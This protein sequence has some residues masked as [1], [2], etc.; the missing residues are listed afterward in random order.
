MVIQQT[1]DPGASP[2]EFMHTKQISCTTQSEI[3]SI[4]SNRLRIAAALAAC[5]FMASAGEAGAS[6]SDKWQYTLLNPTPK[7]SMREMST[8]RPDQT[9]SAMTV[10][11]GHFQIE[12]D[13]VNATF[14]RDTSGGQ[15]ITTESWSIAPVNLK[16]GL[17]NNVDLQLMLDTYNR[18]RIKDE[19][20]GTIDRASGFGDITTRLKVNLWGND[21][22]TTALALMP[23]VKWPLSRSNLRNGKTEGGIIVPLAVDLGKGWGLGAMTEVDF[24]SDGDSGYDSEFVN[25]ITVSR[26]LTEKL[27]V[28]VEFFTVMGSAPGFDW[29]GQ[30]DI[31]FTYSLAENLNLD[32]G[33]NFG[34][35]KSAPDYNPFLGL[36]YRF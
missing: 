25:S 8:D 18:V 4:Q 31:G 34:V 27:G 28:Y 22:G 24:V 29:Q 21:G 36:S 3:T 5:Q 6:P 13:L 12:M 9:E 35:T 2:L 33:C 23:F 26:D 14:D 11:A 7:E 19:V 32:F 17:L 1:V 10:D 15:R 30:A 20:A 16:A